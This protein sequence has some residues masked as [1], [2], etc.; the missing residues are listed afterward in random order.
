MLR[1]IVDSTHNLDGIRVEIFPKGYFRLYR[2]KGVVLAHGTMRDDRGSFHWMDHRGLNSDEVN[3]F[4]E[5]AR[6]LY[7]DVVEYYEESSSE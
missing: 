1:K 7:E 5:L 4:R 6:G 2:T 3:R